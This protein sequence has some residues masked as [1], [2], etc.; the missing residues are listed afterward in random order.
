MYICFLMVGFGKVLEL[1]P[2]NEVAKRNLNQL[3]WKA[4]GSARRERVAQKQKLYSPS[5]ANNMNQ[6]EDVAMEKKISVVQQESNSSS[7]TTTE[8]VQRSTSE[9]S[10]KTTIEKIT[11]IQQESNVVKQSTNKETT[12]TTTIDSKQS[13]NNNTKA[14]PQLSLDALNRCL[15]R[16]GIPQSSATFAM[17][18]NDIFLSGIDAAQQSIV[19]WSFIK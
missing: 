11:A 2:N 17:V 1:E 13:A 7:T 4:R 12:T 18:H 3:K 19:F 14:L 10:S 6:N 8:T 5:N 16:Y 15:K 9:S